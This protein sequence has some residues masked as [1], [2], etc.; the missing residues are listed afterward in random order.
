MDDTDKQEM[1]TILKKRGVSKIT[2]TFNGGGDSG[3]VDD[4]QCDGLVADPSK[5]PYPAEVQFNSPEEA[6]KHAEKRTFA[7]YLDEIVDE[8]LQETNYDWYNNDG[9]FGEVTIIPGNNYIHVDM[10]LNETTSQHYPLDLSLPDATC[11]PASVTPPSK[12]EDLAAALTRLAVEGHVTPSHLEKFRHMDTEAQLYRMTSEQEQAQYE[13]ATQLGL[14]KEM[15]RI[16]DRGWMILR[17]KRS[18]A[19]G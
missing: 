19:N 13:A 4:I 14:Q 8:L 12:P 11:P 18:K 16:R 5:F 1:L 3:Q 2:A 6:K 15:A 9:G 10:N 17:E 7:D